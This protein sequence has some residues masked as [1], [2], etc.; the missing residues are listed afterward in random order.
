MH[1]CQ[2]CV[3]YSLI[4]RVFSCITL[5]VVFLCIKVIVKHITLCGGA[6]IK[7]KTASVL[8][9]PKAFLLLDFFFEMLVTKHFS[10]SLFLFHGTLF[11]FINID[12]V[13]VRLVSQSILDQ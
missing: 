6:L 4:M 3:S 10:M 9:G 5:A 7:A 8:F 11:L 12:S 1:A 13:H 2:A